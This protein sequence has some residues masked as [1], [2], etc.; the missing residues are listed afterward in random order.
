MWTGQ[1]VQEKK[2]HRAARDETCA[3]VCGFCS[4]CRELIPPDS[5]W[6][7][8][9]I[10]RAVV[11]RADMPCEGLTE[12]VFVMQ[13]KLRLHLPQNSQRP[14]KPTAL[15]RGFQALVKWCHFERR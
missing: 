1:R 14:A 12:G 7:F 5:P 9:G 6:R 15:L 10:C 13:V 3:L 11:G 4:L 8:V 2:N